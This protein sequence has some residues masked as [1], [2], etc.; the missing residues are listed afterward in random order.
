MSISYTWNIHELEHTVADGI[1]DTVRFS[2]EAVDGT[3]SARQHGSVALEA[4]AEGA[5]VVPYAD[6]T[7]AVVTGWVKDVIGAEGVAGLQAVLKEAVAEQ[8]TPTEAAG[9]PW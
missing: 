3:N 6:L 7:P 8:A 2:I 5:E 1:V 4:P 9:L